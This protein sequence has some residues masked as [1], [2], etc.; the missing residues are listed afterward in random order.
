VNTLKERI[1][2]AATVHPP[3]WD[4]PFHC[5]SDGAQSAGVGGCISVSS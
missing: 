5:F 4:L 3:N 1:A 2:N